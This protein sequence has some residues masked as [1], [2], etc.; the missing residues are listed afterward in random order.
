[1]CVENLKSFITFERFY[2]IILKYQNNDKY[3]SLLLFDYQSVI[4][5]K[6]AIK[7]GIPTNSWELCTQSAESNFSSNSKKFLDTQSQ[8]HSF[9]QL[10]HDKS[11]THSLNVLCVYKK[12]SVP[13]Y[14]TSTTTQIYL[15]WHI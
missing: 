6:I 5:C 15:L 9:T 7:C 12:G 11:L 8:N 14:R 10:N 3:C 13:K 1:M 4:N 2:I